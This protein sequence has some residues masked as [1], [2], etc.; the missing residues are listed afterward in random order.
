MWRQQRF[1]WRRTRILPAKPYYR[2]GS[3]QNKKPGDIGET[4]KIKAR[5]LSKSRKQLKLSEF[6]GKHSCVAWNSLKLLLV[7]YV[8]VNLSPCLGGYIVKWWKFYRTPIGGFI[9]KWPASNPTVTG[10]SPA[11]LSQIQENFDIRVLVLFISSSSL[12][13]RVCLTG[14][15]VEKITWRHQ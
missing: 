3:T 1:K 15:V 14:D 13:V 5:L 2:Q 4:C 11:S 8:Y 7:L 9:V 10:F 6:V 12:Y